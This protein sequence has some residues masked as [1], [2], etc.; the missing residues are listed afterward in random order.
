MARSNSVS[1]LLS[2]SLVLGGLWGCASSSTHD[3]PEVNTGLSHLADDGESAGLD[4]QHP[5]AETPIDIAAYTAQFESMNLDALVAREQ[6]PP[7]APAETGEEGWLASLST[8]PGTALWMNTQRSL[9]T[10]R[11]QIVEPTWQAMLNEHERRSQSPEQQIAMHV[12]QIAAILRSQGDTA[13]MDIGR[14]M[15]LSAM[16][17]VRPGMLNESVD[18]LELELLRPEVRSTLDA[19]RMVVASNTH[20][21]MGESE[22]VDVSEQFLAAADRVWEAKPMNIKFATLARR[23]VGYGRYEPFSNTSFVAGRPQR[24]IVYTEIDNFSHRPFREPDL[25]STSEPSFGATWT[26]EVS[27][28]LRLFRDGTYI[29][30]K[31]EQTILETSRNKR[32]D[33]YLV[34]Q[35][36]LPPTLTVGP[37]ELK[38]IMRDKTSG[39]IDETIIPFTYVADYAAAR[40]E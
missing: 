17:A 13:D 27:Q 3:E 25:R 19:V 39:E 28:E 37:Y 40:A 14:L 10:M 38:I 23:V 36:E 31:G 7:P 32:R 20:P 29:W 30:G 33:F 35:I 21:V 9:A 8:D 4:R 22:P 26:V 16:E 2:A 15:A 1:V 6:T 11:E 12:E 5:T 34:H 18:P 24:M